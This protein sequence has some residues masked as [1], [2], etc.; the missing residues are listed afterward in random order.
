MAV[1]SLWLGWVIR[2]PCP[3]PRCAPSPTPQRDISASNLHAGSP[4]KDPTDELKQLG[5]TVDGLLGRPRDSFEA[6]RQFVANA[7][8]E[9]R[10]HSPSSAPCRTGAQRSE[11]EHRVLPATPAST[12]RRRRANKNVSSKRCSR[13]PAANAASTTIKNPVDPRRHHGHRPRPPQT[14][15]ASPL[16]HDSD[17]R[18]RPATRAS[19]NGSSPTSSKR[20]PPQR[21]Q[22]PHRAHNPTPATVTQCSPSQHRSDDPGGRARPDLPAVPND[23]T[24][25]ERP[26]RTVSVSASP[27]FRRSPTLTTRPSPHHGLRR[28]RP[29]PPDQLPRSSLT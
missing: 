12:A 18:T 27:S 11:R 15:R 4:S 19:S 17:R 3:A 21:R 25:P 13:S 28:R 26:A 22:R 9:L 5:T 7:S 1:L 23:S 6:Q 24:P 14:T 20:D 2:R 16:R 29:S 8:H 10:T